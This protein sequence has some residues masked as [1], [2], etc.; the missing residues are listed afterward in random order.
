VVVRYG[1]HAVVAHLG[2]LAVRYDGVPMSFDVA[3][4]LIGGKLYLPIE[5]L[6]RI[7]GSVTTSGSAK[8]K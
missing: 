5:L 7:T 1:G 3:P 2:E 6:D 8:A 4:S